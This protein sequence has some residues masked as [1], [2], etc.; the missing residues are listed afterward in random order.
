MNEVTALV[1]AIQA[2]PSADRTPW[3][4]RVAVETFVQH[5]LMSIWRIQVDTKACLDPKVLAFV[6]LQ[7][8]AEAV[9]EV[10][11]AIT[12]YL[13]AVTASRPF[14]DVLGRVHAELLARRGGEGLGQFF[15]PGD[16][17]NLAQALDTRHRP[18]GSGVKVYDSCC[19]AGSLALAAIRGRLKHTTSEKILVLAGDIDPLCA[20]MTALQIHANQTF[21]LLPLGAVKVTVGNELVGERHPGYWSHSCNYE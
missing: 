11:A 2:I 8:N 5:A 20:A 13:N 6:P 10:A 15:I 12:A 18:N 21:H 7:Q 16:L 1:K 14:E 17:L 4:P 19:G 9:P 3:N